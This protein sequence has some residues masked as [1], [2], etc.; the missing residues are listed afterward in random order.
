MEAGVYVQAQLKEYQRKGAGVGYV[1]ERVACGVCGQNVGNSPKC[2]HC[3]NHIIVK[4]IKTK[5]IKW[6]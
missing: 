2:R 3:G 6:L 1:Y 5:K 4:I